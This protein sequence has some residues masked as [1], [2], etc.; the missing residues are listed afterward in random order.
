MSGYTALILG[1]GASLNYGLPLGSGLVDKICQLLP[2]TDSS[3]MGD[4]A[5]SLHNFLASDRESVLAWSKV[6]KKELS[7]SLIEFRQRLIESAPKSI[8][9]FLSRDFGDANPIFRRIGKLA[10]AHVIASCEDVEN[11]TNS[12]SNSHQDHWYRYL[13][14]DCLNSRAQSIDDVRQK[15]IKIISFN[16]DRSLEYFLGRSIAATYLAKAGTLLDPAAI[17]QWANTGFKEV[18]SSFD[19]THP[20]GTLGSL[21]AIEYGSQNNFRYQGAAMADGIRVIGE[22]RNG[23]DNFKK[24]RDWIASAQRVVCLGFSFDQT[25]MARLGLDSGL[26]LSYMSEVGYVTREVSPMTYGFAQAERIRLVDR[27][28]KEFKWDTHLVSAGTTL[29]IS[30]PSFT[31]PITGYLRHFGC[32]TYI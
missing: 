11:F 1:A 5:N 3:Y 32:L 7:Y 19:I 20:Y 17:N 26:S 27:Y 8:D 18:E 6:S 10:I 24:A 25:N 31:P 13:W 22:E 4:E 28:F 12:A 16:Y 9:E 21:T 15:K 2:S 23:Q 29:P 30:P 14:Q